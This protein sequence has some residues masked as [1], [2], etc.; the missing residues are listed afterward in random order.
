MVHQYNCQK[1]LINDLDVDSYKIVVYIFYLNIQTGYW[2]LL[3]FVA[4]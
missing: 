3:Y 4:P 2:A 1:N